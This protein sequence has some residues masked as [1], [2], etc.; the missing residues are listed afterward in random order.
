MPARGLQI[1]PLFSAE[2]VEARIEELA[3]QL[4]LD[5]AGGRLV[6]LS[7]AE[8]ALRFTEALSE[9]L[10][11]RGLPPAVQT[12]RAHRSEGMELGALQIESFEVDALDDRDVLVVDDIA[13]EGRTLRAVLELLEL[14]EC[15]SVRTA[16]LVNKLENRRH[17][18]PLDYVGFEVERGWVGGVGMDVDGELRDLDEIG[19]V[20]ES[21]D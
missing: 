4:Y 21:C 14:S 19:V 20:A 12:V 16:V 1:R 8:G 17:S 11:S 9:A 5:Y 7:I 10:A 6:I 2:Q 18:L 13:D 15:R 3:E